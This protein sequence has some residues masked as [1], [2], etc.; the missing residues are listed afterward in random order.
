[1]I[2]AARW[3]YDIVIVADIITQDCGGGHKL[4]EA[5]ASAVGR[6]GLW[7]MMIFLWDD[8]RKLRQL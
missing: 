5:Y 1:M 2:D 7:V 4:Q 6:I 8:R 3:I